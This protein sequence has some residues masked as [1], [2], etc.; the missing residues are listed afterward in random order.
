MSTSTRA[1]ARAC[2]TGWSCRCRARW[3]GWRRPASPSTSTT[4]RRLEAEF[5]ATVNA[6]AEE[7]YRVLGKQINLGSPKQLQVVLFDELK[8]PKTR[9]TRTGYTTDADA[10]QSLYVKTEHPFLAQMLIHRDA[11]RLKQTVEGLLKSVGRRRAHPHHVRADHRRHRPA[12][13]HRSEPAEHPDP[14]QRGP[15]DPGG[16]RGRSGLR[17]ADVGRLL[18]DRDADHGPR[19]RRRRPDRGVQVRHGLPHGDGLAGL[20]GGA[21]RGVA[22]GTGARSRR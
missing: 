5:A 6:A 19:Q 22:G 11:I 7:A 1:A 21:R 17:V 16:V 10:L 4:W 8:M 15:P 14:D 13:Q 18:P 2:C 9:R 20:R 3:P 12:V